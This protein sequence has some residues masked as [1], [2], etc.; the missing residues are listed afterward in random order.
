MASVTKKPNSQ[1]WFACFR[2]LN[3]KQC[4]QSTFETDRKK[5]LKVAEE[6]E[7]VVTGDLDTRT[8][9]ETIIKLYRERYA[10]TVKVASVRKFITGWIEEKKLGVASATMERYEQSAKKL[11]SFLGARADHDLNVVSRQLLVEFRAAVSKELAPGTANLVLGHV[12][13]IFKAAKRDAYIVENPAEFLS[14]VHNSGS[15]GRRPFTIAQIQRV[16]ELADPEWRSLILCGFYTGQRLYDLAEL[17]WDNVD[18]VRGEIRLKTRKTG[19]RLILPIAEP[20]KKHLEEFCQSD[21]P[22]APLHPRAFGVVSSQGRSSTLSN[23]FVDLLVQAGFREQK[24][25]GSGQGRSARRPSGGL[26]F[27]SLRH[28]AVSLLKDAGVP[29]AAVMEMIGHDSEQMSAHYTHVGIEALAKAA[30]ALPEI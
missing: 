9:R 3:G 26:S 7:R 22:G 4:R 1:F 13:M 8:A 15:E 18:L 14:H 27:H 29:E 6:Y 19:K 30:A 24:V 23:R 20:L 25:K 2:D 12:R 11:L 17:T 16:L 10:V 28:T 5:A 21:T